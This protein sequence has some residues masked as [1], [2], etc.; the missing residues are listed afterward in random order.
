MQA[1]TS[2]EWQVDDSLLEV[3]TDRKLVYFMGTKDTPLES[4][5]YITSYANDKQEVFR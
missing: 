4:H 1:L 3:D 2:G 5:L